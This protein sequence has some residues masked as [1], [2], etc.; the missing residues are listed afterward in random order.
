MF[1]TGGEKTQAD[2]ESSFLIKNLQELQWLNQLVHSTYT[3]FISR[4][5]SLHPGVFHLDS[6]SAYLWIFFHESQDLRHIKWIHGMD[7][8]VSTSA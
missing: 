3:N 4:G 1:S 7:T 8:C 2:Q 5:L 6:P